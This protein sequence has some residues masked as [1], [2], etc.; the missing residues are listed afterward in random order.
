MD[1]P[2]ESAACWR[3]A[4]CRASSS[5]PQITKQICWGI[6]TSIWSTSTLAAYTWQD[7]R[8]SAK[9]C[10]N[11]CGSVFLGGGGDHVVVTP[12]FAVEVASKRRSPG[13]PQNATST[14]MVR[15]A[16]GSRSVTGHRSLVDTV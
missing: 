16:P 4:P 10:A 6:R 8:R 11:E 2:V 3:P 7:S 14:E 5:T 9:R 15:P 13:Y 12:P 1:L